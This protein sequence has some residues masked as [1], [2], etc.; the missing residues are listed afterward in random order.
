MSTVVEG[1]R[2]REVGRLKMAAAVGPWE[3]R[4]HCLMAAAACAT[5][6]ISLAGWHFCKLTI[7]LRQAAP[8]LVVLAVLLGVAGQYRWRGERRLFQ[9]VMMVFWIIL[10]TNM[11][12]FPMYMAARTDVP[13]SD[14]L[15][16]RA[17]RAIGIEVPNVRAA[18]APYPWLSRAMLQIYMTLIPLMTLA[19]VLPPLMNRMDKAKE[20]LIG[21]IVA[22][23]ISLP[24]FACLQAVGPWQYYDFAPAIPSLGG[25]AAMMAELKTDQV[26]MI[27]VTNRDGLIEF[28]SFHVVLTVLAAA[29]L[30]PFRWLRWPTVAW[31]TLIVIST[32]TTGIHYSIDVVGGL[33]VAGVALAAARAYSRWESRLAAAD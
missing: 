10:V 28:P 31:A 11:H 6:L 26:F 25:K 32:I 1:Q 5:L 23:S 17:D 13:I 4:F 9:V 12:F 30:W 3:G 21:C 7:S 14:A 15:F 16:A 8:M 19:A 2:I 33:L 22:A 24:I 18:L 27:D 29:A 20:F